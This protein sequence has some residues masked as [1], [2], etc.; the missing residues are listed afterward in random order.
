MDNE[1]QTDESE[2]LETGNTEGQDQNDSDVL[3]MSD[4]D[5]L[6]QP[7][8]EV[9]QTQNEEVVA[10][11]ETGSTEAEPGN[12]PENTEAKPETQQDAVEKP[13]AQASEE[14]KTDEQKPE[15]KQDSQTSVIQ[16]E[17]KIAAYDKIMA[18]IKANGK[19][20]QL[21]SPEEAIQLIQMGANYTKK[22][23][24]LQPHLKMVK[25]LENNGLLDET[26]LSFLID[27]SKKNPEAIKKLLIDSKIDPMDVD[28]SVEP[29]YT[30]TKYTPT[31]QQMALDDAI[32]DVTS[33][34]SGKQAIVII[35][36]QW[37]KAS[38]EAIYKDP[39]VLRTIA[40]HKES[41]LYDRISGEVDRQRVLGNLQGMPFIN[42]YYQ[43][44]MSMQN[45]GRLI[46][47]Q[48]PEPVTQ[49]QQTQ[50]TQPQVITTRAAPQPKPNATTTAAN[51]D[52]AKAA[53]PTKTSAQTARAEFNPLAMSDE[54][55]LKHTELAR[56]VG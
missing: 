29:Q 5:F 43:V 39:A 3:G 50:A 44:G 4:E 24:A 21:N 45:E 8:G 2:V 20:I 28:T 51:G 22:M 38:K 10:D 23:Q 6:A 36:N 35:Q 7:R 9:K 53:S 33:T 19:E 56:R 52:K 30:P 46:P 31:D 13:D 17:A 41:G 34:E 25:M 26:R 37:D 1:N 14:K 32:R 18:P 16:P 54:E 47:N 11:G 42:A 49:A 40:Q 27:V 55:F 48:S 15:A 12:T